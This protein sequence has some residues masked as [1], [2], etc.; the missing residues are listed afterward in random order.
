M[1]FIHFQA[2]SK[3]QRITLTFIHCLLQSS[4]R[5]SSSETVPSVRSLSLSLASLSLCLIPSRPLP[6]NQTPSPT[7][8]LNSLPTPP[9]SPRRTLS[10]LSP[11]N[12]PTPSSSTDPSR[13]KSR[14][15]NFSR[16]EPSS[17]RN[18]DGMVRPLRI[19][20]WSSCES[21]PPVPKLP[22]HRRAE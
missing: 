14:A 13:R 20:G 15:Q 8:H 11:L 3:S 7:P 1:S 18:A 17:S 9:M 2:R 5:T 16:E 4:S 19:T 6:L 10:S 22:S 21:D 12:K